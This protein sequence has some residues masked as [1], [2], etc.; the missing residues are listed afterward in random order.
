VDAPRASRM[1]RKRS[2]GQQSPSSYRRLGADLLYS[3]E[4]APTF[5]TL[6]HAGWSSQQQFQSCKSMTRVLGPSSKSSLAHLD[7]NE[8][9]TLYSA[10]QH[11]PR[12]TGGRHDCGLLK[13]KITM[14][15]C[16]FVHHQTKFL[17]QL[18]R[19][20]PDG[21]DVGLLTLASMLPANRGRSESSS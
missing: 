8:R 13:G 17:T 4:R 14:H 9:S 5:L 18:P 7:W 3:S 16:Y 20:Q 1:H 11:I 12:V 15:M 6:V 10:L 19:W 21:N 2:P